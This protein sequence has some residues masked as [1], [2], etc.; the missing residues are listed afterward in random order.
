[1]VVSAVVTKDTRKEAMFIPISCS[2]NDF[3]NVSELLS[4][5]FSEFKSST[6]SVQELFLNVDASFETDQFRRRYHEHEV[7]PK[8]H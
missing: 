1:M 5:L 4:E 3:Y 6:L 7:F 8:V 2:H